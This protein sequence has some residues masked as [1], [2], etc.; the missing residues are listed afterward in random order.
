MQNLLQFVSPQIF[1]GS[2]VTF[3]CGRGF[4][5][6]SSVMSAIGSLEVA[7][8]NDN[9]VIASMKNI[10]NS[11]SGLSVAGGITKNFATPTQQEEELF[12]QMVRSFVYSSN[13]GTAFNLRNG[14]DNDIEPIFSEEFV[15]PGTTYSSFDPRITGT[16]D[17]FFPMD[18]F[19]Y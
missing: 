7:S 15:P 6:T 10:S 8:K 9:P 16:Y 12:K 5:T 19:H 14:I 2:K 11:I 4:T 3:Y 1:D 18:L 13:S 17:G